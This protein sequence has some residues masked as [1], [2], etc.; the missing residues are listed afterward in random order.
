VKRRELGLRRRQPIAGRL[1]SVGASVASRAAIAESSAGTRAA[2]SLHA[3]IANC[4]R[5]AASRA[6]AAIRSGSGWAAR[7]ASV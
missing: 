5:L 3:V 2:R 1:A 7:S 4:L 6:A